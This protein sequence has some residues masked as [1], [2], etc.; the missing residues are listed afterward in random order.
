MRDIICMDT[1]TTTTFYYSQVTVFSITAWSIGLQLNFTMYTSIIHYLPI[2]FMLLLYSCK[3]RTICQQESFKDHQ[4]SGQRH[5][6][7]YNNWEVSLSPN[8]TIAIVGMKD[9]FSSGCGHLDIFNCKESHV[10][11]NT[12]QCICLESCDLWLSS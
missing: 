5:Q 7:Y 3:F 6:C 11:Y 1:T 9:V 10:M 2:Q 8:V 12:S 4:T